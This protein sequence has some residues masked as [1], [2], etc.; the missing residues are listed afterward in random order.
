MNRKRSDADQYLEQY[1]DLHRW[2]NVCLACGMRGYKP[3]LPENIY[4]HFNV[5]A[6]HLRRFFRPLRLNDT[7]LCNV[8]ARALAQDE[9]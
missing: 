4:R 7:G 2:L 8:C 5:A 3:D 6:D 1:P 9:K